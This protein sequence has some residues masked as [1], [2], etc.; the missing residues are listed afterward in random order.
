MNRIS[1]TNQRLRT[2]N[3]IGQK[4]DLGLIPDFTARRALLE[5]RVVQLLPQWQ[6]CDPYRGTVYA[7]YTPGRHL[8]LKVRSFIDYLASECD[9]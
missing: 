5:G 7:V 1:P 9:V 2:L 3:L 8:A 6:L 4:V